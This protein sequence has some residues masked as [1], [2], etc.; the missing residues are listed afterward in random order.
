LA[1]AQ[2]QNK[3]WVCKFSKTAVKRLTER[4]AACRDQLGNPILNMTVE[5]YYTEFV[6]SIGEGMD[7]QKHE[8]ALVWHGLDSVAWA[9]LRVIDKLL[10]AGRGAEVT[11]KEALAM[12]ALVAKPLGNKGKLTQAEKEKAAIYDKVSA[13]FVA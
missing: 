13:A 8:Q 2:D 5:Q 4:M 6:P 1:I 3:A 10:I 9:K 7:S 12:I 11:A